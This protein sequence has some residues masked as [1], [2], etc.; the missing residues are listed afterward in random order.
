MNGWNLVDIGA[1][2]ISK[3]INTVSLCDLMTCR[4]PKAFYLKTCGW[5]SEVLARLHSDKAQ[6]VSC[7]KC[8]ELFFLWP[9]LS[10]SVCHILPMLMFTHV[11]CTND[12]VSSSFF[13]FFFITQF[14]F[15]WLWSYEDWTATAFL[16]LMSPLSL[17]LHHSRDCL[18]SPLTNRKS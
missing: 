7:F 9:N 11:S 3:V 5:V 18:C 10:F 17:A 2:K 4:S 6:N 12:L 1:G 13:L 15:L 8:V 16:E 14:E